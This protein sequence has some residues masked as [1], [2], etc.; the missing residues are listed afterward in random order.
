MLNWLKRFNI[1]SFLANHNYSSGLNF[2]ENLL[3][4]GDLYRLEFSTD[5]TIKHVNEF[6]ATQKDW[7][8]FH[9]SFESLSVLH[10]ELPVLD[11]K[12]GFLP[13]CFFVPQYVLKLNEDSIEIGSVQDD[14]ELIYKQ[15]LSEEISQINKSPSIILKPKISKEDYLEKIN[16][17][18]A[19]IH[20]GDCYEINFCQEFYSDNAMI[21]PLN[22]WLSLCKISPN[23]FSV[24]YKANASYLLSASPERFLCKQANRLLSQPMKGTIR[25]DLENQVHDAELR[26]TL[27]QSKKDQMENVMVVDLVRNDLSKVC[28]EGTVKV[29]ELFGVYAFPQVY[30]M[31]STIEGVC[32]KD[33]NFTDIME[34]CFPMGS[35]TGAPKHRVL[36]LIREF[37]EGPRGLFSG[38]VG[39]ITPEGNFDM[40]VVIRSV[41]YNE[42][43]NFLSYMTGSGITAA[44]I[45]DLEYEECLLKGEAIRKALS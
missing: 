3:G 1:C 40:N 20:R 25:R 2:Q 16:G 10:K 33:I 39:Y 22:T 43:T 6:L 12:S 13:F 21:D 5:T 18:L 38:S 19:H 17:L 29:S 24:F 23:P 11:D 28:I 15:I 44:S 45:P 27:Q 42:Q 4:A 35:M 34:A 26:Q 30:Q 41:F 32:K 14:H 7:I 36:E 9:L 8:F 37:E 31:I